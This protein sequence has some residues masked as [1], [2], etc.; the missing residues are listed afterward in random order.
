MRAPR[1]LGERIELRP[2]RRADAPRLAEI[3]RHPEVRRTLRAMPPVSV[4]GQ[5]LYIDAAAESRTELIVGIA[6]RED[7]RLLGVTGL[8]HLDDPASKA[9]L[10]IFI[11]PPVE[12]GKGYGG[13][14]VRLLVRHGFEV[15]RLN[16]IWLHVHA[17]HASAIRVYEG[18]GFR[19][20][21]L[22]RQSGRRGDELV[23]VAVMGV[24]RAEWAA[25]AT[26]S[27][28]R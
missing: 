6:A 15:L 7:G 24:L 1:L 25:A 26:A 19:R 28:A 5:Q 10:G 17:D 27:A 12:W 8:H 20:E 21:G 4:A 18:A 9:E 23:D 2:L 14:A 13:E 22:L 3:L 16:R 11:G